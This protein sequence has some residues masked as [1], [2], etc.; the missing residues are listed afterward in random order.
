MGAVHTGYVLYRVLVATA[1]WEPNS[2]FTTFGYTVVTFSFDGS[3]P[4]IHPTYAQ[5]KTVL[6]ACVYESP[7]SV[8]AT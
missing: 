7:C 3:V 6:F 8:Y 2:K 4:S 5:I 1:I